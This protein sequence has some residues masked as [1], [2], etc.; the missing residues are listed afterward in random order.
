[1]KLRIERLKEIIRE[2]AAEV[3]LHELS[4]PRIG[5]CTVTRVELVDDLSACTIHVS[6]LGSEGVKSRTLHGLNDAKGVIQ[7]QLARQL[8]TRTTPHVKIE[9]D[10]SIEK[11]FALS[12]KIREA[13]ASD[14]DG[15]KAAEAP[16]PDEENNSDNVETGF[17]D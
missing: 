5:F 11:S 3:I 4:D 10:E 15:G 16:A 1:M 7:K 13:R 14:S 2:T 17:D 6:V 9:L 8:K 12:E